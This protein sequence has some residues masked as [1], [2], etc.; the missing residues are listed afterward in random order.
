VNVKQGSVIEKNSDKFTTSIDEVVDYRGDVTLF[1]ED[2]TSLEGYVFDMVD[3][4][5]HIF[6][7]KGDKQEIPLSQVAKVEVTGK[8]TAEGKS[9][10]AWVAKKKKEKEQEQ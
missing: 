9:W 2:G 7:Q 3:D 5:I 1:L 6:P 10:E 8:D 4:H